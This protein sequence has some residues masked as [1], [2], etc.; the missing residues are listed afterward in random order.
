MRKI[1]LI[2]SLLF[3]SIVTFGQVHQLKETLVTPPQF[4]GAENTN[5]DSNTS[6]FNQFADKYVENDLTS[7]GVVVVLFTINKDGSVSDINLLNSVSN[8]TNNAVINCIEK[9]S[10]LWTPGKVNGNPVAMEKEIHFRFSDPSGPSLEE[11]ANSNLEKGLKNYQLGL[12]ISEKFHL[13]Q[14]QAEKKSCKKFN[15]AIKYL[16]IA[17]KYQPQEPSIIF[18]Q[19]CVY[20]KTGNE[21][22]SIEKKN[23]FDEMSD[24]NYMASIELI[25]ID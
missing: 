18:W 25:D 9:S 1:S 22:M 16:E 24:M 15:R 2:V 14:E 3:L 6:K 5:Y 19:A 13:T 10:G 11:M 7:N 23:R 17:N 8:S 21:M 12:Y 20:E 4:M